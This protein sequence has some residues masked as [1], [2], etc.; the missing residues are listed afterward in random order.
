MYGSNCVFDICAASITFHSCKN[1]VL[2]MD[3][4]E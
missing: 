1:D 3:F 4:D 2:L